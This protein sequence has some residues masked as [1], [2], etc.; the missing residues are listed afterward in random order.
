MSRFFILHIAIVVFLIV[1]KGKKD[2]DLTSCQEALATDN[3]I[4][5]GDTDAA[6]LESNDGETVTGGGELQLRQMLRRCLQRI[7]LLQM[8][9]LH[10]S[11]PG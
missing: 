6:G 9:Q 4:A 3:L 7:I 8:L 5:N 2:M 10:Q 1:G 11:L